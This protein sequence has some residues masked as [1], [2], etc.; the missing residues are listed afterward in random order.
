M[1]RPQRSYGKVMFLHLSVIRFTG[2][3][4]SGGGSLSRRLPVWLR[5]G[6][7]HPIG[8]HSCCIVRINQWLDLH[9]LLQI[10]QNELATTSKRDERKK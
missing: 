10:E 3:C 1:N 7:K 5:A 9:E 4:L 6:G 8:M 2:G